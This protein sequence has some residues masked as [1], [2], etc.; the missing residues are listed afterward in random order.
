MTPDGFFYILDRLGLLQ[1]RDGGSRRE[2]DRVGLRLWIHRKRLLLAASVVL[3][4]RDIAAESPAEAEVSSS[5]KG[6]PE[7]LKQ[8]SFIIHYLGWQGNTFL[9]VMSEIMTIR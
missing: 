1:F 4:S 7:S 2:T 3:Y 6:D 8:T 5:K 9:G